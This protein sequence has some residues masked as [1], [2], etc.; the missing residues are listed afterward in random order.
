MERYQQMYHTLFNAITDAIEEIEGQDPQK[1]L[2]ILERAQKNTEV[3]YLD[4]TMPEP[5]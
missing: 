2:F 1:A 4:D 3:I 5:N